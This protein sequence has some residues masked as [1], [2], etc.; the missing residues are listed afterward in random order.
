MNIKNKLIN[1]YQETSDVIVS[2]TDKLSKRSESCHGTLGTTLP[3]VPQAT[4]T[5]NWRTFLQFSWRMVHHPAGTGW[6][7]KN[8]HN[9]HQQKRS[10]GGQG[11]GNV[12]FEN[13]VDLCTPMISLQILSD[14][15]GWWYLNME[16][17][18]ISHPIWTERYQSPDSVHISKDGDTHGHPRP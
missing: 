7:T 1:K 18:N 13:I 15:P 8:C 5:A 3:L 6:V 14:S 17:L 11:L 10:H 12:C 4:R 2:W 16:H 9:K